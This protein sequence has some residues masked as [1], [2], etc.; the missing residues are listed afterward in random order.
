MDYLEGLFLG[1]QWSDTDFQNR[2][3]IS[4]LVLY[5]FIVNALI[6]LSYF[7]GRFATLLGTG[8]SA[9]IV[10][11]VVLFFACPFICFRYYRFPLWGKI[12]VI[13][14][15]AVKQAVLTLIYTA[16]VLPRLTM[17]SSEIVEKAV[18]YLNSTLESHT[19]KWVDSA[20][21]FA[22]ILGVMT[23]GVY[24]V[25]IVVAAVFVAVALPAILFVGARLLQLLYDKAMDRL[26]ITNF[27]GK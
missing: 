21:T 16:L 2:R 1:V 24:V 20:G 3:H 23:G 9:K 13:L 8:L 14:V 6:A 25:F 5:G 18:D 4:S 26:V 27:L 17:S 11:F 10:I 7:T 15:Q 19:A 22:T 12:P